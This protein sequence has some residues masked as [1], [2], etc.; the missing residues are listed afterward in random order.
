LNDSGSQFHRKNEAPPGAGLFLFDDVPWVLTRR[1]FHVSITNMKNREA[2]LGRAERVRRTR[3]AI[4]GAMIGLLERG[5]TKES[6]TYK[7]V[8]ARAG[9]TEMTVYRYFPAR[10]DLLKGLWEAINRRVGAGI[11]MPRSVE[12]LLAQTP[13][14]FRGF[15]RIPGLMA[16][17]VHSPQGRELR[18]SLN[19]E[20]REAFLAIVREAAGGEEPPSAR[21][22]AAVI[23]LL[24]S[25]YAWSSM[26]EQWGLSGEEAGRAALWA[27]ET[28]LRNLKA[29]QSVKRRKSP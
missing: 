25:A 8:A 27:V 13:A 26:R 14:L 3:E 4:E 24:H 28:L 18:A 10:R 20:R 21:S 19:A 2:G 6:I 16:A 29:G 7:A 22:R 1:G 17:S 11:V 5:G 12:Q 15:D 23:Q 9:V